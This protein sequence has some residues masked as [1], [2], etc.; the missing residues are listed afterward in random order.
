MNFVY[1]MGTAGSGKSALTSALADR[2]R[3]S[4]IDVATVNLD[5]GVRWLPYSPEVDIREYVNYDRMIED[6]R[7]GPNGALVAC[8]DAAVNHVKEM[9]EELERLEPDYVLVDTPGQMELFAYRDSGTFIAS[10]LSGGSFSIVF[11][12][13]HLFLNKPS[14]FVSILLLS[15]SVHV[16][17][18]APQVNCVSKIDLISEEVLDKA[19][20]W[21]SDSVTLKDAFLSETADLKTEISE[22][23][24][25]SLLDI[26]ALGEFI[27]ISSNT[28]DGLDD[29]YAQL[30]RIHT[31]GIDV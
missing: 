9:K 23:I 19:R 16:R 20:L 22:R 3:I 27:F 12:A 5:P 2:L 15:Y 29:L 8:V 26:G 30:Q 13:D 4:D 11:L 7:L 25:D 1:I 28:G 14:D 24:L 18:R 10:A 17:F 6:Y 31:G 21:S